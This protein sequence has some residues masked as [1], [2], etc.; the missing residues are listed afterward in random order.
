MN[1]R[2]KPLPAR[3]IEPRLAGPE[4]RRR[5]RRASGFG[6]VA[7][8]KAILATAAPKLMDSSPGNWVCGK[9]V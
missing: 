1:P 8:L 4:K 2:H 9:F 6:L 5:V 7:N 3:R